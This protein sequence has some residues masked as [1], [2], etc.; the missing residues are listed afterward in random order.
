M[1]DAFKHLKKFC[2]IYINDV[3]VFSHSEEEHMSHL[4]QVTDVFK[5]EGMILSERKNGSRTE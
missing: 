2:A 5:N 3:L 4:E 1:D